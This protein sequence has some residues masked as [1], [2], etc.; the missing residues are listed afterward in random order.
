MDENIKEFL[1]EEGIESHEDLGKIKIYVPSLSCSNTV[2]IDPFI[3]DV[4]V[5]RAVIDGEM[6]TILGDPEIIDKSETP[7]LMRLS[8]LRNAIK[9]LLGK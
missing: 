9:V 1:A 7:H 5:E 4:Y 3:G 6:I 8:N 2:E